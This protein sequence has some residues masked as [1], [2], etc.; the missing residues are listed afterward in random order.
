MVPSPIWTAPIPFD[1]ADHLEV[2]SGSENG[3]R[4]RLSRPASLDGG[5]ASFDTPNPKPDNSG[6]S[7]SGPHKLHHVPSQEE[8]LKRPVSPSTNL[9]GNT[10][11]PQAATPLDG[12]LRNDDDNS[13][14]AHLSRSKWVYNHESLYNSAIWGSPHDLVKDTQIIIEH[15]PAP[16]IRAAI[17]G[18]N[19]IALLPHPKHPDSG[20]SVAHGQSHTGEGSNLFKKESGFGHE[21]GRTLENVIHRASSEKQVPHNREM[22]AT[23]KARQG[24][25]S[26]YVRS[27][28]D[29]PYGRLTS[30]S[31]ERQYEQLI[32]PNVTNKSPVEQQESECRRG[33]GRSQRNITNGASSGQQVSHNREMNESEIAHQGQFQNF[34]NRDLDYDCGH[35]TPASSENQD[36]QLTSPSVVD[37]RPVEK[38][39]TPTNL[40]LISLTQSSESSDIE[41]SLIFHPSK[42]EFSSS[43]TRYAMNA[44]DHSV[45][46]SPTVA[47]QF[48]SNKA[49]AGKESRHIPLKVH[50]PQDDVPDTEEPFQEKSSAPALKKGSVRAGIIAGRA[51]QPDPRY[52]TGWARR[53]VPQ[54]KSSN[55]SITFVSPPTQRPARLQL[56]SD[57][58]SPPCPKWAG[59][60][61]RRELIV[62][63]STE[64]LRYAPISK[65]LI[66][67]ENLH[68][69]LRAHPYFNPMD[70]LI[71][72]EPFE[73]PDPDRKYPELCRDNVVVQNLLRPK[74]R[75]LTVTPDMVR[76]PAAKRGSKAVLKQ[77]SCICRSAST[78]AEGLV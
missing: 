59:R 55:D 17:G 19:G 78:A 32:S 53:P 23:E 9:F 14:A 30:R 6:S 62:H 46:Y 4:A 61:A 3:I 15:H 29:N 58:I 42:Q 45:E 11:L 16:D 41:R 43:A 36:D 10:S 44:L 25:Y 18:V 7:R 40:E 48:G 33:A 28:L 72:R 20:A 69:A 77:V 13:P 2:P 67:D 1:E 52:H 66:Y 22:T 65:T 64:K 73:S 34:P 12:S 38:H 8:R 31:P 47:R 35:S 27:L 76:R 24:G 51:M 70:R 68:P 26:P 5:L 54:H 74:I 39:T 71:P 50:F 37:K 75:D 57:L 60:P 63:D 49:S 21:T 56:E